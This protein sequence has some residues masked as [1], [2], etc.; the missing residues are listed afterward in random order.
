MKAQLV[1]SSLR[2]SIFGATVL[3]AGGCAT[4]SHV[5]NSSLVRPESY[6]RGALWSFAGDTLYRMGLQGAA[7]P[8]MSEP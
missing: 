1:V 4:Q 3:L 8:G 5:E 6:A 2:L 7:Y